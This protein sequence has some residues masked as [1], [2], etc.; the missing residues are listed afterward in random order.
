MNRRAEE[1]VINIVSGR[2]TITLKIEVKAENETVNYDLNNFTGLFVFR[3][4]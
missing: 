2:F 4:R 3:Q 1:A